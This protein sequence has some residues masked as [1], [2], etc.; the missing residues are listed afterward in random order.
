MAYLFAQ[1]PQDDL[2]LAAQA[3]EVLAATPNALP[4]DAPSLSALTLTH[5]LDL[6]TACF[7][8]SLRLHNANRAFIDRVDA[9]PPS[10]TIPDADK[11]ALLVIPG[12]FYQEHP[13]LG[14]DGALFAHIAQ[15][16]GLHARVIPTQSLGLIEHN[17]PTICTAIEA[18]TS[19]H[20]S[21]WIL[22]L[23]KGA[24]D[25]KGALWALEAAQ[26]PALP[27][28]AG[29]INASGIT[30]GSPFA[31]TILHSFWLRWIAR[32]SL[33]PRRRTLQLIEQ[34]R[35]DHPAARPY[36]PPPTMTV[37]NI[38]PIPLASHLRLDVHRRYAALSAHGPNDGI[39]L[40]GGSLVLPGL[41]YPVWGC[42]HYLRFPS[43]S[44]LTYKILASLPWIKHY[45]GRIPQHH[46]QH[47]PTTTP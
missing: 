24:A 43:L 35:P 16:C 15:R 44:A 21:V 46:P 26:S 32:L 18:A 27:R 19:T 33:W 3:R 38:C 17:I 47:H 39:A 11:T 42:D 9:T 12:L 20:P 41:V 36:T 7:D 30:A 45:P 10:S 37:I 6:A 2:W 29:W 14:A 8:Q 31:Y 28:I 5:S 23:S 40:L 22:S 4:L 25:L 34:M 1:A 13:S